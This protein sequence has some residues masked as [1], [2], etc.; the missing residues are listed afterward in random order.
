[1][2]QHTKPSTTGSLLQIIENDEL[3]RLT[4][5][6][7]IFGPYDTASFIGL[8]NPESFYNVKYRAIFDAVVRIVNAK[9]KPNILLLNEQLPKMAKENVTLQDILKCQDD[10][11][12]T[13]LLA[14]IKR[15]EDLRMRRE[16]QKLGQEMINATQDIFNEIQHECETLTRKM[17]NVTE[18]IDHRYTTLREEAEVLVANLGTP[19]V[20][21]HTGFPEIDDK[22]GLPLNGLSVIGAGTSQG[23]SAFALCLAMNAANAGHRVAYFSLEM[24][25]HDLTERMLAIQSGVDCSTIHSNVIS[26][27]FEQS[28]INDA[29]EEF[30]GNVGENIFFD[31]NRSTTLEQIKQSIR[32]QNHHNHVDVAIIDYLQIM[33]IQQLRRNDNTEQVLAFAARELHNLAMD[34]NMSIIAISQLNRDREDSE[35]QLSRLR[36]SSQ[37]ADAAA[38]VILIYRPEKYGKYYTGKFRDVDTYNTA[39]IKIAKMRQGATGDFICGFQPNIT[40]FFHLD[41]IRKLSFEE[42]SYF[43]R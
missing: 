17:Q 10:E 34:C 11:D 7:L 15:L 35:P 6:H 27:L 9:E 8:L 25:T 36:D 43:K 40:K 41:N 18:G 2:S 1:M 31:D 24:S 16:L 29:C 32:Y 21:L 13:D 19:Y 30:K 23:K 33:S 4:L 20:G 22:G 3:E 12:T 5:S 42:E 14:L 26:D 39:L 38:A 37:I 28:K